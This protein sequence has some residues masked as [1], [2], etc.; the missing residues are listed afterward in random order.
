MGTAVA[1]FVPSEARTGARAVAP[2]PDEVGPAW[3]ES[4]VATPSVAVED[5]GPEGPQPPTAR[6]AAMRPTS[7]SGGRGESGMRLRIG[8]CDAGGVGE[9]TIQPIM[10]S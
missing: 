2:P 6:P 3:P 9:D 10:I 1:A 5:V 7:T 8:A 4:A